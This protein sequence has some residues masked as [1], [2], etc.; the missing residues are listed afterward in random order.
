[1]VKI[2]YFALQRGIEDALDNRAIVM[3]PDWRHPISAVTALSVLIE[4]KQREALEG[5]DMT[6]KELIDRYIEMWIEENLEEA[7]DKV[8][9]KQNIKRMERDREESAVAIELNRIAHGRIATADDARQARAN[10]EARNEENHA[11]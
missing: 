8:I 7:L 5:A 4:G 3:F 2:N 1:M 10:V 11:T 9:R 6:S